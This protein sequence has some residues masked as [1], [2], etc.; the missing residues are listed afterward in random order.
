[1][2]CCGVFQACEVF[3]DKGISAQGRG[4]GLGGPSEAVA[5]CPEAEGPEGWHSLRSLGWG[6]ASWSEGGQSAPPLPD[7]H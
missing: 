5:P 3:G 4:S 1:M 6:S 7:T 2:L